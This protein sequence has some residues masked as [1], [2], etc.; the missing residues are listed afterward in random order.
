MSSGDPETA[1]VPRPRGPAAWGVHVTRRS[2]SGRVREEP[3]IWSSEAKAL[4][5]AFECSQDEGV[6]AA[7]VSV[8]GVDA[9]THNRVALYQDGVRQR[10]PYVTDDA[11]REHVG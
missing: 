6:L 8:Y 7:S 2:A 4:Q 3:I 5:D 9:R 10:L 1:R 11:S